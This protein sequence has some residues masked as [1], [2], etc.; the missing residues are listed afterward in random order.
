MQIIVVLSVESAAV[1]IRYWRAT[2]ISFVQGMVLMYSTYTINKT[3]L[4]QSSSNA[5]VSIILAVDRDT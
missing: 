4:L 1:S 2:I 3:N 5:Q